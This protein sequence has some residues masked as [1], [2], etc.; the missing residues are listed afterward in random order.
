M[1]E[2]D[3]TNP[4]HCIDFLN[5]NTSQ[6]MG[7]TIGKGTARSTRWHGQN[8]RRTSPDPMSCMAGAHPAYIAIPAA[9]YSREQITAVEPRSLT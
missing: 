5:R 1:G 4:G 7:V 9:C 2:S 6:V 8:P 3:P